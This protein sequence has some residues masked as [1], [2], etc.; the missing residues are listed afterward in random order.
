MNFEEMP[1]SFSKKDLYSN[2]KRTVSGQIRYSTAKDAALSE[3]ALKFRVS[4]ETREQAAELC[5]NPEISG[6]YVYYDALKELIN[7][8]IYKEK[9][10]YLSLPYI[11]RGRAPKGFFDT[12]RLWLSDGRLK[13]FLVRN[14]ETLRNAKRT[15][16]AKN[17][18]FWT[19][20]MYTWNDEAIAFWV[21]A[22]IFLEI[23]F[24]MNSTRKNFV[25]A[26]MPAAK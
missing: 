1:Y 18:A 21:K 9:E 26:T 22:K 4:C 24:L 8:G 2:Q 16:M 3:K 19:A 15:W 13:G 20:S 17:T 12:C 14:L 6:L 5:K 11:T 7:S 23:R 10:L 25:T